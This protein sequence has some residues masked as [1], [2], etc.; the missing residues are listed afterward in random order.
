MSAPPGHRCQDK[1]AYPDRETARRALA[2]FIR[3]TGAYGP[4]MNAYQCRTCRQ[5]HFGRRPD[6]ARSFRRRG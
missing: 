3:I 2:E 6:F 1:T 5:Y 4:R